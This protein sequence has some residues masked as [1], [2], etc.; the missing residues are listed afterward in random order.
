M[1]VCGFTLKDKKNAEVK[2]LFGLDLV[3][4]D[5]SDMLNLNEV[6]ADWLK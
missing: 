6:E 4:L 3:S 2:E 1:D 5:G